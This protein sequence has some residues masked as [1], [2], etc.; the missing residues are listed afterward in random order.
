MLCQKQYWGKNE[1]DTYYFDKREKE[2][3]KKHFSSDN[4]ES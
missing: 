2:K 1:W 4:A 3:R